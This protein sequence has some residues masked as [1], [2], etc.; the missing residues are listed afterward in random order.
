MIG[1]MFG[2]E[3]I[4]IVEPGAKL[5]NGMVMHKDY[6]LRG[7]YHGNNLIFLLNCH[8]VRW[9]VQ[10]GRVVPYRV[11]V[12]GAGWSDFV[13]RNVDQDVRFLHFVEEGHDIYKEVPSISEFATVIGEKSVPFIWIID[14][15]SCAQPQ[16][17]QE[18]NV[19]RMGWFCN[20]RGHTSH[21]RE[22]RAFYKKLTAET[23]EKGLIVIPSDIVKTY[24]LYGYASAIVTNR[25]AQYEFELRWGKVSNSL[26]IYSSP[27]LRKMKEM[28]GF[29]A[30]QW[31]RFYLTEGTSLK[32]GVIR[33][34]VC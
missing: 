13:C 31:A 24:K 20:W 29:M 25:D 26:E 33:L 15:G 5:V 16:E 32:D 9:Q 7:S 12:I 28:T 34:D 21:G 19:Q 17:V 30:D 3:F 23:L 6:L 11:V 18:Y 27:I 14:G 8:G 22:D 4:T 10:L 1:R 2:S